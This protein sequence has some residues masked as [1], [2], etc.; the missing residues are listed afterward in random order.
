MF[1][2]MVYK[3][4]QIFLPFC[5]NPRVCQT[6]GR[7]DRILIARPRYYNTSCIVFDQS[8]TK[9]E[10]TFPSIWFNLKL[11]EHRI[12]IAG[13]TES[14]TCRRMAGV[15]YEAPQYEQSRH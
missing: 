4:G 13:R 10:A 1:F 7:T 11:L 3:S 8:Q 14:W 15:R 5:H 12:D 2:H 6:D 9:L